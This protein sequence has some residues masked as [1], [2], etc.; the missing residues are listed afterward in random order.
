MKQIGNT[1]SDLFIMTVGGKE[2]QDNE[3][4]GRCLR[5]A[6][7]CAY[8]KGLPQAQAQLPHDQGKRIMDLIAN[9][10]RRA[11]A[12]PPLVETKVGG[13]HDY[14]DWGWIGEG[15]AEMWVFLQ[16]P[17]SKPEVCEPGLNVDIE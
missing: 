1:F 5:C 10:A 13:K 4:H 9:A 11:K 12:D 8:H 14:C 16:P 6:Y 7:V 15:V 3:K 2:L 17:R